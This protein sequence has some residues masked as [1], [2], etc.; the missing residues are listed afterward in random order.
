MTKQ[1][2]E[3]QRA[4]NWQKASVLLSA[5]RVIADLLRYVWG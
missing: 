5:V 4:S 2:N 3:E 1:K